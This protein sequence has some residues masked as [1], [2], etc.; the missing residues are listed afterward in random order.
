MG[1][2]RPTPT[3][4]P[5]VSGDHQSKDGDTALQLPFFSG[6]TTPGKGEV[7]FGQ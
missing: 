4:P 2:I 7:T 5:K 6:K 3:P 1:T